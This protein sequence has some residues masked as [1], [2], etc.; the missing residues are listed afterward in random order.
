MERYT[1]F[2]NGVKLTEAQEAKVAELKEWQNLRK[3]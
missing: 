3:C 2:L 1:A